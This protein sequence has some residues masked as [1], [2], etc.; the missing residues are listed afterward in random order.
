[1][2]SQ[3]S[4]I[5]SL[6]VCSCDLWQIGVKQKQNRTE[7]NFCINFYEAEMFNSGHMV[8]IPFLPDVKLHP[9]CFFVTKVKRVSRTKILRN[10]E[11]YLG[12]NNLDFDTV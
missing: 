12:I 6:V 11:C 5:K 7:S 3:T 8:N 9:Y 2:Q 4:Q 1:M 10:K